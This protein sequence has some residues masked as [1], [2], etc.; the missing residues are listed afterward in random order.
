MIRSKR[1]SLSP[2][3]LMLLSFLVIIALGYVLLSLPMMRTT[4]CGILD[5]WFTATSATCVTG[6]SVLPISTFSFWGKWVILALIQIGGLGLMTLSFSVLSLFLNLGI[7]DRVTAGQMLDFEYWGRIRNFLSMIVGVTFLCELLGVIALYP[8][9]LQQYEPSEAFFSALF[10]SVSAFCNAGISPHDGGIFQYAH[11]GMFLGVVA[12]L[13]FAGSTGFFV[14]QDVVSYVRRFFVSPQLRWSI[15]AIS[16]HSYV[17]FVASFCLIGFTTWLYVAFEWSN[18]FASFSFSEKLSNCLFNAVAL[19]SSGFSTIDYAQASLP[20]QF[21]VIFL[22]LIGGSPVSTA[23]GIKTTTFVLLLAT[24]VATV[25][26]RNSVEIHNR[27]I[28]P[29]QIYKALVILGLSLAWLL[30]SFFVLLMTEGSTFDV[31]KLFFEN[32]AAFST[33]GLS[34]GIIA[35]LSPL[36][37][38][39]LML[40][41]IVGRVGILTLLLALSRHRSLRNYKY[42]HERVLIG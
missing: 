3:I 38:C 33:C 5:L 40:N 17:V 10:Y 2:G 1:F 6:L 26:A 36:G 25:K 7:A 9:M 11:N 14:W 31:F 34:Q 23:S 35:L 13:V 42:P 30:V 22:M 8:V 39:V 29:D 19:R 41:M 27:T 28:P 12:A 21:L 4:S 20:V 18:S 32:V 16:L 24:I 37:K 15:P